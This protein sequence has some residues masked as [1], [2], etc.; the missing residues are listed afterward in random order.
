MLD[1]NQN[2]E[3]L[4]FDLDG[5]VIDSMPIHLRAWV[6]VL[7][8]YGIE[9]PEELFFEF[10]GIPTHKI[11]PLINK[12]LNTNLD[13]NEISIKKEKYYMKHISSVGI[14]NPVMDIINK[15]YGKL[16]ISL[17]TGS[18][19]IITEITLKELNLNK[20][21]NIYVTADDVI[22]HKPEPDTFLKCAEL[23]GVSPE[24][25]EVFEDGDVGL[26]AAIKAGMIA[27]DVRPYLE[28]KPQRHRALLS[29]RTD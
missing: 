11:V 25:C 23:M 9:Y 24:V 1:K 27:T 29:P 14:I 16:P 20:Y 19:R 3:A 26:Q 17:G 2:A 7:R 22:N 15:Y 6:D 5:T 4:I 13:S 10:T 8:E 18:T 21:F 28:R 12:R